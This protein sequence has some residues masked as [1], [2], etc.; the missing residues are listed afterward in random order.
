MAENAH[1]SGSKGQDYLKYIQPFQIIYNF[2]TAP[3]SSLL[4]TNFTNIVIYTKEF[5]R[6]AAVNMLTKASRPRLA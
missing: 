2:M 5:Q 3:S 6:D 4:K 1:F